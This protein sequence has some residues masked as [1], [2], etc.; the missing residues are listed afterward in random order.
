MEILIVIGLIW[1]VSSLFSGG[2]RDYS[3][4]NSYSNDAPQLATLSIRKVPGNDNGNWYSVKLKGY[5]PFNYDS[6]YNFVASLVDTTDGIENAHPVLSFFPE[7]QEENTPAFQFIRPDVYIPA[8]GGWEEYTEITRI[9]VDLISPPKKGKRKLTLVL[10]LYP[11][12]TDI[13]DI[14]Y[15][16][17]GESASYQLDKDF[18]FTFDQPGYEERIENKDTIVKYSIELAISMANIDGN[19][20]NAEKKVIDEWIED[21][22]KFFNEDIKDW[23]PDIELKELYL[24]SYNDAV[25]EVD[26]GNLA[27]SGILKNFVEIAD[28]QSK[29]DLIDLCYKVLAADGDMGSEERNL[30]KVISDELDIHQDL[31]QGIKDEHML[32][33]SIAEKHH[34]DE[35]VNS[36]LGLDSSMTRGEKIDKLRDDFAKWNSRLNVVSTQ[37]EKAN[38]QEMIDLI[39]KELKKL[40]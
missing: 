21:K 13:N 33:L 15:G 34:T 10:R 9:P 25:A 32:S 30:I 7:I 14:E 16:F 39:S 19:Y 35:D 27:V 2:S 29:H 5:F 20:D 26:Q 3:Y 11:T 28:E 38:A 22:S 37:D 36:L 24:R 4:A 23:E 18:S 40:R 1:F 31:L 8:Y 17:G 12:Y 6:S